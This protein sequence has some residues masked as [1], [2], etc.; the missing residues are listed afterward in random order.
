MDNG[1]IS[2]INAEFKKY[3]SAR[4]PKL[5][6]KRGDAQKVLPWLSVCVK[7]KAKK[8]KNDGRRW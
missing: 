8:S 6:S 3:K 2:M 1:I 7:K 5:S 4:A